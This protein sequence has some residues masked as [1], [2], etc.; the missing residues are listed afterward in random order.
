MPIQITVEKKLQEALQKYSSELFDKYGL[1]KMVITPL[2]SEKALYGNSTHPFRDFT[3]NGAVVGI[4]YLTALGYTALTL[5]AERKSHLLEREYVLGVGKAHILL[6]LFVIQLLLSTTQA[7]F[8]VILMFNVF[9]ILMKG[10]MLLVTLILVL[11][12]L[13]GMSFG[14]FLAAVCKEEQEIILIE[15]G[16][17]YLC[18]FLSGI[19]WPLEGMPKVLRYISM[20]S[21]HTLPILS[22]RHVIVR[23]GDLN[24]LTV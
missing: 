20:L 24:N 15:F 21:P 11:Q 18:A 9:D 22:L 23:G 16:T 14:A 19:L 17:Y 10:S 3:A 8:I 2:V 5:V 4:G 13:L 7:I 12:S 6:S 1:N